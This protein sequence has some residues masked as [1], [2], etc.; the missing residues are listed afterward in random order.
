NRL[1][2]ARR[3]RGYVTQGISTPNT[4][5]KT[6]SNQTS[7]GRQALAT[8][9]RPAGKQ[10]AKRWHD[11]AHKDSQD[12]ARRPFVEAKQRRER[13]ARGTKFELAAYC[14]KHYFETGTYPRIADAAAESSVSERT[15]RRALKAAEVHLPRGRKPL[16]K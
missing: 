9:G 7:S 3:V 12:A 6:S 2:M 14:H 15:V 11:P 4:S 10:A 8:L 1:T 13:G 5:S 16:Q